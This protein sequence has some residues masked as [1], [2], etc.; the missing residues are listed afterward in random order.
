MQQVLEAHQIPTRLVD[1]GS[2]AY[3]GLGSPAAVQV[4][5]Q[6]QWTARLLLSAV[7]EAGAEA[8]D[9]AE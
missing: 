3:L 9:E 2:V 5:S 4:Q 8:E 6:D 7:E 1:L